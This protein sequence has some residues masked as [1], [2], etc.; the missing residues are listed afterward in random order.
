MHKTYGKRQNV[1]TDEWP[2]YQ[3][4]HYTTLALIH[5]EKHTSTEVISV[6]K[7]WASKGKIENKSENVLKRHDDDIC[8]QSKS[9]VEIFSNDIYAQG[10]SFILIEGAPGIGK[11]VLSKEIAYQWANNSL[12]NH[13][14]FVFLL[15]LRDPKLKNVNTLEDL[16]AYVFKAMVVNSLAE[17]LFK[18]KG[19]DITIIL[20]GYDE[21]SEEHR[22]NSFIADIINRTVL[23]D[24][25]L[26]ITSR[27][28]ASACLHTIADC[29][30]EILGFTESDR[31]HYIEHALEGNNDKIEEV[32]LYLQSH[33]TINALCYIPL[34]MT[35]LLSLFYE[36]ISQINV[37]SLPDTQT[38]M[39]ERFI[40]VTI[41]RFLQKVL[42]D[43]DDD[44]SSASEFSDLPQPHNNVFNELSK[45]A[46]DALIKDQIVFT[47]NEIIK[48]CPH[49][50]MKSDNWNGLGLIK[51]A[52]YSDDSVS[53]HFLHFSV[54]EYMAAYYIA[55]LPDN[56]QLKLLKTTFW[57]IHYFNTWIMYVGITHGEKFAWKHYLS[58]NWFQLS[59]HLF[60]TSGISKKL[61][62]NK[63][64]CLHLF[65]CIVEGSSESIEELA[66]SLFQDR[67]ID[68]SNQTLQPKDVNILGFF[69]LRSS[70]KH[71]KKIN[72]SGCSLRDV[73][74][75]TLCNIFMDKSNREMFKVDEVDF[76]YNQLQL[77]AV[78]ALLD[79]IKSWNTTD[80]IICSNSNVFYTSNKELE[81]F[82]KSV[83]NLDQNTKILQSVSIGQSVFGNKATQS[84]ISNHL[85]KSRNFTGLYLNKCVWEENSPLNKEFILLIKKQKLSKIHII[86]KTNAYCIKGIAEAMKL[87]ESV[88]I[89]N[90]TLS[91]TEVEKLG[92]VLLSK[93]G[94]SNVALVIGQSKIKGK[95]HTDKLT[96]KLSPSELHHLFSA[97]MKISVKP[98]QS[99]VNYY[100]PQQCSYDVKYLHDLFILLQNNPMQCQVS[101]CA[102]EDNTLLA[103]KCK[104]E[105]INEMLCN[106]PSLNS[107]YISHCDFC[108]STISYNLIDLI[109]E[110]NLLLNCYIL[111]ISW[112]TELMKYV[113]AKLIRKERIRKMGRY[114]LI[115]HSVPPTYKLTPTSFN[116][117]CHKEKCY[118]QNDSVVLLTKDT[119][120]GYHVTNEFFSLLL[121]LSL[122]FTAWKLWCCE[123]DYKMLD[124][125]NNVKPGITNCLIELDFSH[126][127]IV[128]DDKCYFLKNTQSFACLT[129][130]NI[131][132]SK[133]LHN[134]IEET[135]LFLL[136]NTQLKELDISNLDLDVN[137]CKLLTQSL[138]GHVNL[139]KL[140]IS[141]I[142]DVIDDDVAVI[143]SHNIKI[144]ELDLSNLRA[145]NFSKIA[146]SVKYLM[147]LKKLN[148]SS[149]RITA[150]II[151]DI[152]FH[153][154]KLEHLNL[155]NLF[156]CLKDFM[157]IALKMKGISSL[158]SLDISRN[159]GCN[160]KTGNINDSSKTDSI[161]ALFSHNLKI[162]E[163]SLHNL[164][165]TSKDFINIATTLNSY[166]ISKLRKLNIIDNKIDDSA[167]DAM[168]TLLS[169]ILDLEI[170]DISD[171]MLQGINLIKVAKVVQKRSNLTK[172]SICCCDDLT[173][174]AA[175]SIAVILS[176]SSNLKEIKLKVG[177][178][179][180]EV[181]ENLSRFVIN[182]I[183]L[184]TLHQQAACGVAA[185]LSNCTKLEV[186][187]MGSSHLEEADAI[188][189]SKSMKN[190]STLKVLNIC[191]GEYAEVAA[192]SIAEVL[193]NNKQ[194][195]EID[196][197][198][199]ELR[200][201]SAIKI[202]N[203]MKNLQHLIKL[204]VSRNYI[205]DKEAY[206]DTESLADKFVPIVSRISHL[207]TKPVTHTA[208]Q[209]LASVIEHNPKL[210][211]LNI[212][213]ID[214]DS[215]LTILIFKSMK[216]LT[217]LTILDIGDSII[218]NDA[219]KLL[220]SILSHNISLQMLHLCN[221]SLEIEGAIEVF[222]AIRNHS[223]LISL[224]ICQ[225]YI[226]DNSVVQCLASVLNNNPQLE[227]F[228]MDRI[229]LH[230]KKNYFVILKSMKNFS[231]LLQLDISHNNTANDTASVLAS[232]LS[233][234]IYL[235]RLVLRACSLQTE[236]A[237]KIFNAIE[238]HMCLTYL[239]ITD[240]DD[241]GDQAVDGLRAVLSSNSKLEYIVPPRIKTLISV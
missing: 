136:H 72:L 146:N 229:D 144:E 82:E 21:M 56:E 166:T 41:I 170:L 76:S 117:N 214:L 107:I 147:H 164:H 162:E 51:A 34:N 84:R 145:K 113:C 57:N 149:N 47:K 194:L 155:S 161:A 168:I 75:N 228:F 199:N 143:I 189:I 239:D 173:N 43:L 225:N 101:I 104:C 14:R 148:I 25:G 65:Q 2:P 142:G 127:S 99:L 224:N 233:H 215:E 116:C 141:N 188:R 64:K 140:N 96:T 94:V 37:N 159:N 67:T 126:C 53:F 206:E 187:D 213:D 70:N 49:L 191:Y 17:H 86:G 26:V 124:L 90:D 103:Y 227:C 52:H 204:N 11:T 123:L 35:I 181:S 133:T 231:N 87:T 111:N 55:L 100:K 6:T 154:T 163:L 91:N 74:C 12:L 171:I 241:I 150:D 98:S 200:P 218:T 71:W 153:N 137:N 24:C 211:Q 238:N 7:E 61:L 59:T 180:I 176:C 165:L 27:P 83:L 4:K 197:S 132:G 30:V 73:G 192:N 93:T 201:V 139:T 217:K 42:N 46:Y 68:L 208:V 45:L 81:Y 118:H 105:D 221:C 22:R 219:A 157:I 79:V 169:Q 177:D 110:Q 58:G 36:Q 128:G 193:A 92:K 240:N 196:I 89:Y 220:A 178:C 32:K 95:L 210:Q 179:A 97:I 185:I 3:P 66:K 31:L 85:S 18:T 16:M 236:G 230:S 19:A 186:L 20:D 38:E 108:S 174:D 77:D 237:I 13:K 226:G 190:I 235:E 33:S 44:F 167:A 119:I 158:R 54:Q 23:P 151:G 40:K 48:A 182:G 198:Y 50:T 80:A 156:L 102:V 130:F 234:N 216:N 109:S 212:E 62:H 29:R 195:K 8:Y 203:G 106:F 202:F 207:T 112:N 88:F 120:L 28:T 122:S 129:I 223:C 175:D 63:V 1:S 209:Y 115:L 232:V 160:T 114:T 78:K 131:C 125:I 60:K 172:I 69:L 184:K 9:I 10:H 134:F 121:Q 152:L 15:F 135:T 138:T 222:N 39:Y 183:Y 5:V 205:A